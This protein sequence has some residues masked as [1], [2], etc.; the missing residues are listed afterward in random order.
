MSLSAELKNFGRGRVE[1]W[2]GLPLLAGVARGDLPIEHFRYYL[3]QDYVYLRQYARLYS[4]LAANAPDEHV[5]HLVLL[6]ANLIKVELD[7]HRR[8][9][10]SFGCDFT[11]VTPSAECSSYMTFL[12]EASA[13][14]GEGLVAALPCL[15]GYG[16]ALRMV[17]REHSG[18]Y[19]SWLDIY[20]GGEYAAMIDR[21]C[22]MLDEAD[23]SPAR[24]RELFTIA[25][26][27]EDAFWSQRPSQKAA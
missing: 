27:H 14:F 10:E 1:A 15:W 20:A 23:V 3:E 26:D 7:A 9:G 16:V 13:D 2:T 17:P 4:R 24:A 22:Q 11:D 21:H 18:A 6:A 8:M 5:E 25:L 12:G 19:R